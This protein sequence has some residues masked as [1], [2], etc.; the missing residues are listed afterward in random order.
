MQLRRRALVDPC[1]STLTQREDY[2]H[3]S[4][5]LL[6]AA[7]CSRD[8]WPRTYK[9]LVHT[10][11]HAC[12]VCLCTL[13]FAYCR[14]G[15]CCMH[16]GKSNCC[17]PLVHTSCAATHKQP[18]GCSCRN[19][20]VGAAQNAGATGTPLPRLTCLLLMDTSWLHNTTRTSCA[21]RGRQAPGRVSISAHGQALLHTHPMLVST[22]H[23]TSSSRGRRTRGPAAPCHSL[24]GKPCVL[25]QNLPRAQAQLQLPSLATPHFLQPHAAGRNSAPAIALIGA[26]HRQSTAG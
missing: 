23:T 4:S 6:P 12:A 14:W 5:L 24:P 13:P 26:T 15:C 17:I 11:R 22:N 3:S 2:L 19:D 7:T 9:L 25:T 21:T 18:G 8:S 1:P 10:T 20:P 16:R